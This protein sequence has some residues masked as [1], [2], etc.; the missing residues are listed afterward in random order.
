MRNS[1]L[2][3]LLK[4]SP[5]ESEPTNI[6]KNTKN[7]RSNAS[8]KKNKEDQASGKIDKQGTRMSKGNSGAKP[9]MNNY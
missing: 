2:K 6:A 4:K 8:M 9:I 7:L 5:L 1:P 3:G